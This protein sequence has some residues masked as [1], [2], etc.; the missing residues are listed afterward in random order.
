LALLFRLGTHRRH[1]GAIVVHRSV[2]RCGIL[3]MIAACCEPDTSIGT[4]GPAHRQAASRED[5]RRSS[6]GDAARRHAGPL[7]ANS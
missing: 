5:E 4:S 2:L 6:A 3:E 7:L 1:G